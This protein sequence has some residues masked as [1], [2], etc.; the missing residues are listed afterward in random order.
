MYAT[1]IF[2]IFL[3]AKLLLIYLQFHVEFAT[4]NVKRGPPIPCFRGKTTSIIIK[5]QPHEFINFMSPLLL[6]ANNSLKS[7]E[8]FGRKCSRMISIPF[9]MLKSLLPRDTVECTHQVYTARDRSVCIK[10]G[11]TPRRVETRV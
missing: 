8:S 11:H 10:A 3:G 9:G 5:Y 1:P 7:G 4:L 2:S 6:I